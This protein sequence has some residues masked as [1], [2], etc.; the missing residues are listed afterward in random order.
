MLKMKA[1][2]FAA[3]LS[4]QCTQWSHIRTLLSHDPHCYL[5]F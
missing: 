1:I 5:T 3:V 4:Y 2:V